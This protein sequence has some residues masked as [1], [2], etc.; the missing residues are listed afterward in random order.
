MDYDNYKN[1]PSTTDP[2]CQTWWNDGYQAPNGYGHEAAEYGHANGQSQWKSYEGYDVDHGQIEP[3]PIDSGHAYHSSTS[4]PPP[5][6][7]YNH[8]PDFHQDSFDQ[9]QTVQ[10]TYVNG[11]GGSRPEDRP[12]P[13]KANLANGYRPVVPKTKIK[14][15]KNPANHFVASPLE[16]STASSQDEENATF[17][18]RRKYAHNS[19]PTDYYSSNNNSL[20][21]DPSHHGSADPY[22]KEEEA[23]PSS[24][25]QG[26]QNV[27]GNRIN[28]KNVSSSS[29]SH[30]RNR[31]PGKSSLLYSPSASKPKRR[32]N[33]EW[34]HQQ[35]PSIGQ[36]TVT[37]AASACPTEELPIFSD[38]W[39]SEHNISVNNVNL[40]SPSKDEFWQQNLLENGNRARQSGPSSEKKK[41]VL[42]FTRKEKELQINQNNVFSRIRRKVTD[43]VPTIMNDKSEMAKEIERLVALVGQ[44]DWQFERIFNEEE[45]DSGALLGGVWGNLNT[46]R[47]LPFLVCT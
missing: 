25:P 38:D 16:H 39:L 18:D 10:L 34:S 45:D 33:D 42:D 46:G 19:V 4:A 28:G 17:P 22:V 27:P 8:G 13:S 30:Y 21:F 5:V 20:N 36:R 7:E 11:Q 14:L 32:K 15:H 37:A 24:V 29:H 23:P 2:N 35:E 43:R 31:P 3:E 41:T 12:S 44:C 47:I 1:E 40:L 6:A 9:V 26:Y